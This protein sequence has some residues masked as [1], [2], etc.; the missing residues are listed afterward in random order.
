MATTTQQ[1][2]VAET[3]AAA[4]P[5]ALGGRSCCVVVA[6]NNG[7]VNNS[8]QLRSYRCLSKE[9]H[10]IA[11]VC[12]LAA[13][14]RTGVF[15]ASGRSRQSTGEIFGLPGPA[16]AQRGDASV[17]FLASGFGRRS[18]LVHSAAV[19]VPAKRK[20]EKTM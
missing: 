10:R 8:R 13:P 1:L 3:V 17:E 6:E 11:I 19:K 20:L 18:Q 15:Y 9:R 16:G 4:V 2:R 5:D 12:L 7:K 14:A